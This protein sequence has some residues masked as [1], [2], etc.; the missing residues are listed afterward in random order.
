MKVVVIIPARYASTRFPGKPLAAINGKPMVQ[1]VYEQASKASGVTNVYV[2][3]DDHRIADCVKSF[4]GNVVMTRED[5]QSG[6]DRVYEAYANLGLED[7]LVVNV[8]G[9]EPYIQPEQIEE[10][11]SIF[12]NG[13]AEIGTLVREIDNTTDLF[14]V[15]KV[16]A[17]VAANGRGLYFSRQPLPYFKG[18]PENMWLNRHRYFKHIGMYAFKPATLKQLVSLPV[19]GLELAESLEQLRWLENGFDIYTASTQFEAHAVDTPEDL[20]LLL[21]RKH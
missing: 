15:N 18:V 11:I 6:T 7:D 20:A 16:K 10:I 5:H 4:G 13:E 12:K 21:Q 1:R 2:A 3:T 9:D 17:V 8:Q 14:N 19:S